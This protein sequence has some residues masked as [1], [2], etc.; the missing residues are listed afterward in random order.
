MDTFLLTVA[1]FLLVNVLVGLVRLIR[2]PTPTDR[3]VAALLFGTTGVGILAVLAEAMAT[4][5]LRDVA[6]VLALLSAVLAAAFTSR[7]APP[8]GDVRGPA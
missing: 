2:G 3:M 1:A 7:Q 4:P 5:A 6:L 8:T